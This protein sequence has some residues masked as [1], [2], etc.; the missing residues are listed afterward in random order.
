MLRS[1]QKINKCHSDPFDCAQGRLWEES[2]DA[3]TSGGLL[4]SIPEKD[5]PELLAKLHE[6][7]VDD[8]V[9]IG[10][11][12]KRGEGKIVVKGVA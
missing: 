3:Q 6:S 11:I 7:G 9:I 8:A 1:V 5:S 4:I 10:K 2:G 12:I